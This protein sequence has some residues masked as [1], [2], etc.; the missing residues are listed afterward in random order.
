MKEI[1]A[2][3]EKKKNRSKGYSIAIGIFASIAIIFGLVCIINP[4][5]ESIMPTMGCVLIAIGA[6]LALLIIFIIKA[7]KQIDKVNS[8]P[9]QAIVI[10]GETLFILTDK[11]TKIPLNEVKS[12]RG[13]NDIVTG[14]FVRVIKSSGT[15]YLKTKDNNKYKLTQIAGVADSVALI[16][17]YLKKYKTR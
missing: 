17:K 4:M 3:R 5:Q 14:V 13:M 11:L 10:E 8:Y 16:K 15:I 1:V 7:G 9:E 12:I 6:V 2:V